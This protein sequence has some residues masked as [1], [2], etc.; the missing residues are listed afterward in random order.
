MAGSVNHPVTTTQKSIRILEAI[1][2]LDGGT[3]TEISAALEMNK[4][5]IHNHLQT[6]VASE[7]LVRDGSEYYLSL[8]LLEFGWRARDRQ[9][10]HGSVHPEIERLAEQTGELANLVVEEHGHG[11]YLS[12]EAG[13]RAV[14][15][16]T[17][18][19]LRRPLHVTASGKAILAH[20]PSQRVN[21][22]VERSGLQAKTAQSLTSRDELA[23]E[24]AQV[25]ERKIAFDDEEHV[26]GLRCVA[27][28]IFDNDEEVLGAVSLSGPKD[29]LHDERFFDEL[30]ST[31]KST[32]NVI[33]LNIN[34]V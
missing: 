12:C 20:L 29:R 23:D 1:N 13:D 14:N 9:G 27:A 19:G 28:P 7:L 5:T 33:E 21:E 24:L 10:L 18:P 25:R 15:L 17:H 8:R 22:I 34:N 4:S 26:E 30:P 3:L 16:N 2:Q 6:L 31:V 11:V 32:V